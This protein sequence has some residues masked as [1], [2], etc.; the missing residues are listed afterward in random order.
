MLFIGLELWRL[1]EPMRTILLLSI[2]IILAP[3]PASVPAQAKPRLSQTDI[4]KRIADYFAADAEART[5]ILNELDAV[6]PLSKRDASKW[7]TTIKKALAKQL[8]ADVKQVNGPAG[9]K[10]KK[11]G[12]YWVAAGGAKM[13]YHFRKGGKR[14]RGGYALYVS[15][16]GGGNDPNV[17]DQGWQ[18]ARSRYGVNGCLIAPRSTQDVALSWAVPEIWPL[19]DRLLAECFLLR[20]VDPDQVYI[21]GYSMGGWGTLLMGPAMADRWAAVG[22]SAGGEQDRRAHPENL[23]NTPI[24]IQIGTKDHAFQR[25]ELSKAYADR[26]EALHRADPEGYT[27]EYIEHEG[28]GHAISDANTPK[29]MSRFTRNPYPTRIV[30]KPV[31]VTRGHVKTFY[32]LAVEKPSST[33]DIVVTRQAKD[34]V[35]MVEKAAG[36]SRLILL[37]NDSFVD[38]EKPV[39]VRK[40]G[41]EIFRGPVERRL[42]TLLETFAARADVRLAFPARIVLS[43]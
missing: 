37:L 21:L 40:D 20:N 11:G 33:M 15:F 1:E 18:Q 23:R 3:H 39:V 25:Y 26:L 9:R 12:I 7:L 38:L 32:Y 19:M 43:W 8:L 31:D 28:A 42:G 16:H 14:K 6:P 5:R 36:T 13:K 4:Q 34:N 29:W 35:F 30:W 2:V 10:F 41:R 22:A 17:N 27:F 24:I